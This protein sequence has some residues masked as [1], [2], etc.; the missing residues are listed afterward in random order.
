MIQDKTS[1]FNTTGFVNRTYLT[2]SFTCAYPFLAFIQILK[3]LC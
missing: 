2:I 3:S 1:S